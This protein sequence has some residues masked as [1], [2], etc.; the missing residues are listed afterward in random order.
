[1]TNLL[2]YIATDYNETHHYFFKEKDLLEFLNQDSTFTFKGEIVSPFLM[3]EP[4]SY[5][6]N[7]EPQTFVEQY[8]KFKQRLKPVF[9]DVS[10]CLFLKEINQV[11]TNQ[12][13]KE[14]LSLKG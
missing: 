6:S 12:H 5:I 2:V 13:L 11:T 7:E 1:M 8:K 14:I 9:H 3:Y 10:L 4:S